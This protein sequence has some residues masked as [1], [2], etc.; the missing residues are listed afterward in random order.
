MRAHRRKLVVIAVQACIAGG[1]F[2]W[3]FRNPE[4]W[5]GVRGAWSRCHFGWMLLALAFA[6]ASIAA[7]VWR[8]WFC[9]RL[10]DLPVG[11]GRL[12]AVFLAGSF[13]GTF[14]IGGIGG[15]TARVMLLT[16]VHRGALSRLMVSVV[17]DRLC[18]LVA[19]AVPVVMFTWAAWD[20]LGQ[21][22]LGRGALNFLAGYLILAVG[23]FVLSFGSGWERARRCLPRWL[24]ARAWFLHVS[25]CFR[26]LRPGSTGFAAAAV[27]SVV[28]LFLHF[29]TF[30]CVARGCGSGIR[31]GEMC[32]VLPVVEAATTVP[33]TPSGIGVRE[34]I[35]RDQLHSLCGTGSG[36]AV[37]ISL[38]GFS[39]GMI[40]YLLGGIVALIFMPHRPKLA[41]HAA[42]A[43]QPS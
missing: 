17:A 22:V 4:S 43:T 36:E 9:L 14:M 41:A 15:D 8:W 28:M 31:F 42:P 23:L 19:L 7:H 10:L 37:L 20:R 35:M 39:C 11:W 16:P 2:F 6:G 29:A 40:W 30:W 34:E 33:A 12:A 1:I 25:D 32:A 24:P 38:A 13:I 21:T 3:I 26:S 18:G 5:E 27:S